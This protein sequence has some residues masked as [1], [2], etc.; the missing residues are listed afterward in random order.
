MKKWP[1]IRLTHFKRQGQ[2]Q[3]NIVTDIVNAVW[4]MFCSCRV[5]EDHHHHV[6]TVCVYSNHSDPRQGGGGH[7]A[8]WHRE[9]WHH[10]QRVD[11]LL[12]LLRVHAQNCPVRPGQV[13]RELTLFFNCFSERQN[14]LHAGEKYVGINTNARHTE[15][16]EFGDS[17][18]VWLCS[19]FSLC[20][21][22]CWSQFGI[23]WTLLH[24]LSL[25]L[26]IWLCTSTIHVHICNVYC[27][28]TKCVLPWYDHTGWLGIK[29]Q[30]TYLLTPSLWSKVTSQLLPL[31]AHGACLCRVGEKSA[32]SFGDSAKSF[33]K[34]CDICRM[35]NVVHGKQSDHQ[36]GQSDLHGCVYH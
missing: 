17:Y 1:R 8:R 24:F 11:G 10:H 32:C 26:K 35:A 9:G 2:I 30:V 22:C 33:L 23:I 34:W 28:L 31:G 25:F 7:S 4:G 3:T 36:R 13:A 5:E 14:K 18:P 15:R 19:L 16:G 29:R 6:Y 20:S 21:Y 12:S 27:V